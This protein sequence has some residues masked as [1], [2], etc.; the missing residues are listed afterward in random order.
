MNS[1][2]LEKELKNLRFYLK[3]VSRLEK[4]SPEDDKVI[5][6]TIAGMLITVNNLIDT[7]AYFTTDHETIELYQL[8]K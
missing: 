8:I 1:K 6:H 7:G 4:T 2:S 3:T 5:S